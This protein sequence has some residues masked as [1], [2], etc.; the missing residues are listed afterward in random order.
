MFLFFI[1]IEYSNKINR[2]KMIRKNLFNSNF[3][4]KLKKNYRKIPNTLTGLALGICG[5]STLLNNFIASFD[6]TWIFWLSIPFMAI[7][8]ILLI[9]SI[10]RNSL[11]PKLLT[12]EIKDPLL[13]SFLSTF[14][15]TLMCVGGFIAYWNMNVSISPG[16]IIGAIV[17]IFAIFLQLLIFYYFI[18]NVL[19]KYKVKSDS[20]YGSWFLPSVGLAIVSLF[21]NDFDQKILPNQFFQAIWY[22][23]FISYF[24]FFFLVTYKLIFVNQPIDEKFPT[25]AIYFAPAGLIAASF[26]NSFCIPYVDAINKS[27]SNII[28]IRFNSGYEYITN[29]SLGYINSVSFILVAISFTYSI[30]LWT[31]FV[32]KILKQKFSYVFASLTFPTAIN[33]YAMLAYSIFLEK[34]IQ[35][36][37]D[38]SLFINGL[39][40]TIKIIGYIFTIVST[41]L[42][43]YIF[44]KFIFNLIKDLYI[45][46]YEKDELSQVIK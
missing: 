27:L 14:S 26:I 46:K 1:A 11:N 4:S 42:I 10:I 19:F 31:V 38:N 24:L 39:D 35:K 9:L 37:N 15:M 33:A 30:L 34:Y 22:F 45:K 3:L 36:T 28:H 8:I 41:I 5:L 18:K 29:Y 2:N 13:S 20:V 23:A 32:I 6:K 21:A 12:L 17:I 16:Q 44:L 25:I 43:L 7:A 40:F